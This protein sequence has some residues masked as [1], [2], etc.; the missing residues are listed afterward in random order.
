MSDTQ[1]LA[2]LLFRLAGSALAFLIPFGFVF[3]FLLPEPGYS[4][5]SYPLHTIVANVFYVG[6]GLAMVV[7]S[8]PLALL[9][10]R[11]L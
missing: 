11:G 5:T 6:L 9:F 4:V 3:R 10:G 1:R 8:K 2:A 7:F